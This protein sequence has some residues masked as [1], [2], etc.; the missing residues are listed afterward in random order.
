MIIKYLNKITLILIVLAISCPAQDEFLLESEDCDQFLEFNSSNNNVLLLTR[1]LYCKGDWDSCYNKYFLKEY[2][3]KD[4]TLIN[5]ISLDSSIGFIYDATLSHDGSSFIVVSSNNSLESDG[6]IKIT[7]Y[8]IAEKKLSWQKKIR[9]NAIGLSITLSADDRRIICVTTNEI[10]SMT[11][12]NGSLLNTSDLSSILSDYDWKFFK[13]SISKNGNY[14]AFWNREYLTFSYY[15]EGGCCVIADYLWYGLRWVLSLGSLSNYV[16]IWDITE[17]KII[18]KIPIHF[19]S[20]SGAVTF[21]ND[22]Q[23]LI[24]GPM[25]NEVKEYSRKD[26]EVVRRFYQ[27]DSLR[28]KKY[29]NIS[30]KE[31]AVISPDKKYLA[32]FQNGFEIFVINYQTENLIKKFEQSNSTIPL[33]NYAMAFSSDNRFFGV[34]TREDKI[35][36]YDTIFWELLWQKEVF[37]NSMSE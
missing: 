36:L 5:E 34:I 4:G 24:I 23:N 25:D 35:E 15:D 30:D 33:T 31:V 12:D 37:T 8:L 26:N 3:L 27:P 18:A 20:K 6:V 13:C 9:L 7:K 21:T 17:K 32:Y 28:N 19:E 11:N 29:N 16:F 2:S 14:F 1:E 22:E 10:I